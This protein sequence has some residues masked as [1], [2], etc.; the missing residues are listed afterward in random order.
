MIELPQQAFRQVNI[1]STNRSHHRKVVREMCGNVLPSRGL[2]GDLL[3]T[4]YSPRRFSHSFVPL[5]WWPSRLSPS[6]SIRLSR[7]ALSRKSRNTTDRGS[8]R[9]H[10]IA[11]G[12]HFAYRRYRSDQKLLAPDPV[13]RRV[14]S[15]CPYFYS[16]HNRTAQVYNRYTIGCGV[17]FALAL[18]FNHPS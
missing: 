17:Y 16:C 3:R 6:G 12:S 4:R 13:Q 7:H 8:I 1:Y 5:L 15:W 9:W 11:P 2:F 14:F 10:E 18:G